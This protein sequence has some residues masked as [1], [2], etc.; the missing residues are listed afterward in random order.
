MNS[1]MNN[2]RQNAQEAQKGNSLLCL[3]CL[4]AANPQSAIRNPQLASPPRSNP[5]KPSQTR[6]CLNT[7]SAEEPW[8][9]LA[10]P[11]IAVS[12]PECAKYGG[13]LLRR[14]S[15]QTGHWQF[16]HRARSNPVKPSQTTSSRN[17]TGCWSAGVLVVPITP[18]LH[19][20]I[21]LHHCLPARMVR[22]L[23]NDN[24]LGPGFEQN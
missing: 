10:T 8:I 24:C 6:P 4:F 11:H 1:E 22:P 20:S 21:P 3:L 17:P 19:H 7:T 12:L 18:P 15:R 2:S 23:Q 5:V 9:R 13:L 16:P 14:A